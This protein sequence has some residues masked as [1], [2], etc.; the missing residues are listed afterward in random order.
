MAFSVLTTAPRVLWTRKGR[1][2][3]FDFAHDPFR[4]SFPIFVVMR[5]L[6]DPNVRSAPA[7]ETTTI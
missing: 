3:T 2:S 1:C 4:K 7:L 6:T 5:G